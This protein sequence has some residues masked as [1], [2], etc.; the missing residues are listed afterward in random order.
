MRYLNAP[1]VL[2]LLASLPGCDP[3]VVDAVD[4]AGT[5]AVAGVGG[6]SAGGTGGSDGAGTAGSAGAPCNDPDDPDGDGAPNCVDL[7]PNQPLKVTPGMCGCDIPDEDSEQMAS[8]A[9]LGGALIHRYSF[10]G[11]GTTVPDTI[12]G[13]DANLVNGATMA[14][15]SVHLGG[16]ETDEYVNLRNGI[17]SALTSVSLEAWLTWAGP[18]GGDWQRVFDF[19]DEDTQV[20]GNQS[21]GRTYL[22]MTPIH[23]DNLRARVVFQSPA[24]EPMQREVVLQATRALDQGRPTHVVFTFDDVAKRLA[25]YVD[26]ELD[27]EKVLDPTTDPPMS[28]SAINDVN[29]WLGRSQYELDAEFGGSIDEFRIYASA[30]TALQVRTSNILGPNPTFLDPP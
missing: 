21:A 23:P 1:L 30:L 12:R 2:S 5:G 7:C 27:A 22:F 25:I 3:Q 19:G 18:S 10:N 26:G 20:E 16:G 13:W 9:A 4:G 8:C 17:I 14:D 28:L 15:G 11:T 6:T 29:C 24:A